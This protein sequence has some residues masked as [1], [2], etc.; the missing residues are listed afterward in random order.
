MTDAALLAE[1]EARL[2]GEPDD[3]DL[4][5]LRAGLLARLGRGEAAR[6]AYLAVLA[7]A[8]THFG[9]LN[10]L[11]TLLH[12]SDFRAAARLAYAEAVKHHPDNPIGRINLANALLA[13]GQTDAARLHYQAALALAPEHPDAHQG[14]ANLLQDLGETGAAEAHRQ[15]SYRARAITTLPY[16]GAG[17]GV[18]VLLL[19]SAAGGNVPTRFLLDETVFATSVLVA[20]AHTAQTVLPPHEL[21]FNAIGDADLCAAGLDAAEAVLA[22]TGAPVINPPERI[23]RTGRARIA[24]DL[25]GLEGVRAP[26]I[27]TAP[28]EAV[29]SAAEALGYPLLLRSP[30]HHTGR[31]FLKVDRPGDLA[32]S[33]AALPGAELLAIEWL[34]ARGADGLSRK[35]RAMMIGEALYPL[36][37]AL[38]REWKVHYFTADMAEHP[39]H[40]AEEAAFLADMPGVLGPRAMVGLAAIRARLGLDY[41]GIDFGLGPGGEVLLFEANATMVVNPPDGDPRWDHRREPVQ[42]ILDAARAM[43]IARARTEP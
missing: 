28:R 5:Y 27:E 19:V 11:G 12:N 36:H 9:A 23:R 21:V 35:Y 32:R 13:E 16:R 6:D 30:G 17:A 20:E 39:E 37:L 31:H 26:R 43:L 41:G 2:T 22:R 34:D 1:I 4:R 10:D 29:A 3:V 8:P 14:M 38:S 25:A 42:T 24:R 33:L 40:R 18:P 7:L 15:Q